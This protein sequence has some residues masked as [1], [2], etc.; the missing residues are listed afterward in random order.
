MLENLASK[1]SAAYALNLLFRK[2]NLLPEEVDYIIECSEESC[3]DMNQ[4]GGGNFAKGIG[5][6]CGCLNATGSDTRSFCSAPV[7]AILKGSALVQAGIFKNVVVL[8]GGSSAKLGMNSREHLKKSVPILE[9]MIGA[10]A[11]HISANDGI[12]PVI[13]TDGIG[14][15]NIG[16]G[17]SP[18]ASTEAIVLKP[19][20]K[21]GYGILDIDYYSAE[22]HNPEITEPAGAGNIP[23]ANYK[24]IAA[25]GVQ[26]GQLEKERLLGYVERFGMPG[27]APTQG[28]IPSGVPLIGHFCDLILQGKANRAMIIGKGSLFLGRLTNLF[29]GISFII[30]KNNGLAENLIG[31]EGVRRTIAKA[32]RDFSRVLVGNGGFQDE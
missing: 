29:D 8:A 18:H 31:E 12:N 27:F 11:V 22:M 10:F 20:N 24:M 26:K 17:S 28:H 2:S 23:L 13:R 7:H 25:L 16:S 4:R 1:A 21:L 14:K 19:L 9:D 32:L 6:M 3:G 30:E 5:E 15:H